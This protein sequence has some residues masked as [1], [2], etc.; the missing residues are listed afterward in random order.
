MLTDQAVLALA[1]VFWSTLLA[2]VAAC[3]WLRRKEWKELHI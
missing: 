2:V 1:I 3:V